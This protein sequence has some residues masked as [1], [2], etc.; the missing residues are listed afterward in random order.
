MQTMG[1]P[2]TIT[3]K[4]GVY[5]VF[6]HH[7]TTEISGDPTGLTSINNTTLLYSFQP[8]R[9]IYGSVGVDF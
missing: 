5:N 7:A 4:L 6:D 2:N 8:G 9:L 1:L 3:T